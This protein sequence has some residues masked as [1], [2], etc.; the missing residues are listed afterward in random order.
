MNRIVQTV[1][2]IHTPCTPQRLVLRLPS[3]FISHRISLLP[4]AWSTT[5][6]PRRTVR[7]LSQWKSAP[8][9]FPISGFDVLDSSL[10]IEEETLP[11]SHPEKYYLVQQGEVLNNR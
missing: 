10:A 8:R 6:T 11:T 3:S 9:V 1:L 5:G 7:P 2:N 4:T